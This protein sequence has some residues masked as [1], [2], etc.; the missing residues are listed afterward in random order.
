MVCRAKQGLAVRM[1][2]DQ[3]QDPKSFGSD[4]ATAWLQPKT[5]DSSCLHDCL[6]AVSR[7]LSFSITHSSFLNYSP[8]CFHT[9]CNYEWLLLLRS[10]MFSSVLTIAQVLLTCHIMLD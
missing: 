8:S 4:G 6:N 7:S 2:R 9:G 10:W 5:Q 3:D 1:E